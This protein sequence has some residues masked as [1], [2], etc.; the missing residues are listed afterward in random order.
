MPTLRAVSARPLL[1]EA[2]GGECDHLSDA[3]VV[4]DNHRKE[5][6]SL[7]SSLILFAPGLLDSLKF[8]RAA[9]LTPARLAQVETCVARAD[10][11]SSDPVFWQALTGVLS[12]S[13]GT[14]RALPAGPV[15]YLGDVEVRPS[16]WCCRADPVHLQPH[17]DHLRLFDEQVLRLSGDEAESLI[18]RFNTVYEGED[19]RLHLGSPD[20]WYLTSSEAL[21]VS[22]VAPD[23]VH[24]N[25]VLRFM[26]DSSVA[27]SL[28]NEIQMIFH[29]HPANVA[30]E[31]RDLPAINSVWLWGGGCL[32]AS[33]DVLLPAAWG[34]HPLLR[35][36]W[37]WAGG[38]A[39]ALPD[40]AEQCISRL[41]EEPGVVV[42]PDFLGVLRRA[43]RDGW[44][45]ALESLDAAWCGQLLEALTAGR[46]DEF[47]LISDGLSLR[48]DRANRRR[49]WRRLRPL[50][51]LAA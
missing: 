25:N 12:A 29:E 15:S 39:E 44:L 38:A 36:L 20:R 40:A 22:P 50:V 42:L 21:D 35:G 24:G 26:T 45:H 43:G 13:V 23:K 51:E 49:W 5:P 37:A 11:T 32:P 18:A 47:R 4:Y 33:P 16:G 9:S 17:G 48:L 19:L 7:K 10:R 6:D 31:N 2:L 3:E 8:A 1:D 41:S 27:T 34:R 30:R 46:L 28:I 14:L